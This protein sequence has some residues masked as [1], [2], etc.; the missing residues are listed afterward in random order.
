[1]PNSN[2]R[3]SHLVTMPQR[4]YLA[5]LAPVL[6]SGLSHT[7]LE[8]F[9]DVRGSHSQCTKGLRNLLGLHRQLPT[10][11]LDCSA[12]LRKCTHAILSLS[13]SED[14]MIQ[15]PLRSCLWKTKLLKSAHYNVSGL[16]SIAL[17]IWIY[18]KGC[19]YEFPQCYCEFPQ[20]L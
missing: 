8:A 11:D 13:S 20:C 3:W 14:I 17:Q 2:P 7:N 18:C 15:K 1:M 19:Y 4:L 12:I 6:M 9:C 10:A 16:V 5:V